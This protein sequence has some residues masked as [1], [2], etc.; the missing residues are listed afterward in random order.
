[1]S[2][3]SNSSTQVH[4]EAVKAD[5]RPSNTGVKPTL[6][7][8]AQ[9]A[10]SSIEAVPQ[11][12]LNEPKARTG[13]KIDWLSVTLFETKEVPYPPGL[14]DVWVD[15]VPKN[16][17]DRARRFADGRLELSHSS[18]QDMG[19]HVQFP[20]ICLENIAKTAFLS[21]LDVLRFYQEQGAKIT[22]LDVAVDAWNSGLELIGLHE[23][24][25]SGEAKTNAK[26]GSLV[27]GS[28]DRAGMT[29]YVGSRQSEAFARYYDKAAEQG[30]VGD[31]LRFELQ[32][33]DSK[34]MQAADGLINSIAPD[35]YIVG[36][37]RGHCDFPTMRAW[38][39]I[40]DV[41]PTEISRAKK[42]GSDTL[43]WLMDTCAPSLAR[44]MHL[45]LGEPVLDEFLERV[46]SEVDRLQAAS[47][48]KQN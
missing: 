14:T 36:L 10:K 45:S 6:K 5:P 17:Y 26:S 35:R 19:V 46:M 4:Q 7:T 2:I 28:G 9:A 39:D 29:V 12:G 13:T 34:A 40:M 24:F 27:Q 32:F 30:V 33:K 22:R 8:V 3:V 37:L 21:D 41:E 11:G 1:M 25:N 15:A 43:T 20:G 16:S 48:E 44:E 42:S 47:Q 18:R 31:W 38:N 23:I